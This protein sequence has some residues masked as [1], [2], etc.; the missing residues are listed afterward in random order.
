MKWFFMQKYFMS[1]ASLLFENILIILI[2][3][4]FFFL[5]I[6]NIVPS[7]GQNTHRGG[8]TLGNCDGV[9]HYFEHF[10]KTNNE[11]IHGENNQQINPKLK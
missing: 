11:P 8:A 4:I 7:L 1:P 9:S 5:N 3:F 6:L 10:Y 2:S